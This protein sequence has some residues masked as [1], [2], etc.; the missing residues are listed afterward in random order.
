MIQNNSM[1]LNARVFDSR[2]PRVAFPYRIAWASDYGLLFRSQSE[3]VTAI[4]EILNRMG[5]TGRVMLVG[6]GGSGKTTVANR[7]KEKAA[8]A[9][10]AVTLVNLKH[11]SSK[12][13]AAWDAAGED[14]L[15]RAE[16]LLGELGTPS[17]SLSQIDSIEARKP[18]LIIV[19][20]LNEVRSSVA[21]QIVG[22]ADRLA[23]S[24]INLS[25]ILTDRLTRRNAVRDRWQLALVL[26]IESGA[27][28]LALEQTIGL[29][30]WAHATAG[31]RHLLQS[32]FFLNKTIE[33]GKLTASSTEAIQSYLVRHAALDGDKLVAASCGAYAMYVQLGGSRT[34]PFASFETEVGQPTAVEL[35]GA[36]VLLRE[37]ESAY[38]EHHLFH[39]YLAARYVASNPDVWNYDSL[40][41]ISF[42]A[43]SFDAVALVL[44]QLETSEADRFVRKVYDWNPYAAAYAMS[45][46]S[47]G[48]ISRE[49][50]FVISAMLAERLNDVFAPTAQRSADALSVLGTKDAKRFM[51]SSVEDR[52][53][54]VAEFQSDQLW[55]AEWQNLFIRPLG[56]AAQPNDLA[57]LGSADSIM[58]WTAANVLRRLEIAEAQLVEIREMARTAASHAQ[59]W[60][61][62]HVLGAFPSEES[63]NRLLN[64]LDTDEN[65]WVKYGSLRSV[66]EIAA[67]STALRATVFSALGERFKLLETQPK[68][69]DEFTR[70]AFASRIERKDTWLLGIGKIIRELASSASDSRDLDKWLRLGDDLT[71]HL[72]A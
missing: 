50:A 39:D 51:G 30:G 49:M 14:T 19:D 37:G 32:P 18:K 4:D 33:D 53:R 40:N 66:M 72:A 60:R 36:G 24:F 44:E 64:R 11:W 29:E 68:L 1:S 21:E 25:V 35:L 67:R 7:L 46:A 28:E 13:H 69:R 59:R 6:K 3:E 27:V 23:S 38:F 31:Q 62:V 20:G 22:I 26:P 55:F 43:S 48:H 70:A 10:I 9:G 2:E 58:G 34:F 61:C 12:I 52:L 41:A 71:A 56:S 5:A 17:Q 47:G 16:L 65:E 45:E 8:Q 42:G 15:A 63:L 57:L 54:L